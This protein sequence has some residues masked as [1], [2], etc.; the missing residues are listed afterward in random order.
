M[1]QKD[2]RTKGVSRNEIPTYYALCLVTV[3]AKA[4]KLIVMP[5]ITLTMVN[6]NSF[7]YYYYVVR[8]STKDFLIM[9]AIQVLVFLLFVSSCLSC[10]EFPQLP[11]GMSTSGSEV[12]NY[13]LEIIECSGVFEDDQNFMRRLAYV[14]T[15][16]G[17][18]GQGT[19]G[20]W[21]V[22]LKHLEAMN[23]IVVLGNA[24]ISEVASQICTELGVDITRAV[25]SPNSQDLSNPLVSGVVARFY[26]HYVTVVN[27]QQI[28]P[29]EDV[30]GQ[31][32]FW[33]SYFKMN[34]G[35]ATTVHYTKL[36]DEL[37]LQG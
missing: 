13:V 2:N 23:Y 1:R 31:A 10:A 7:I 24:N 20:M 30:S 14:E 25:R 34:A 26:L 9:N 22:T 16:D 4:T 19:T 12:V 3:H 35:T 11:E 18:E 8:I 27:G 28:Q 17:T 33:K 36:V 6:H 37:K 5:I 29:A 21:N 15:K 32:T